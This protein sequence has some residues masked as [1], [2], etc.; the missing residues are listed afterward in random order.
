MA[1]DFAKGETGTLFFLTSVSAKSV[2]TISRYPEEGEML[3]RGR[4]EIS[5]HKVVVA[6]PAALE[7]GSSV[8]TE[9]PAWGCRLDS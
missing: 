9:F 3:L 4:N 7:D 2:G 6:K 5:A 1:E 8:L